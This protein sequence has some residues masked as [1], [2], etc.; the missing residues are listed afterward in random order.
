[1]Q[2]AAFDGVVDGQVFDVECGHAWAR[3]LP[4]AFC[5]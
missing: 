1:L 4:M 3:Y 5:T 2:H